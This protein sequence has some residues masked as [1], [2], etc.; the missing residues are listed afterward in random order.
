MNA[1]NAAVASAHGLSVSSICLLKPRTIRKTTSGK[2]A[3]AWC[4]RA[5]LDGSLQLVHRWDRGQDSPDAAPVEEVDARE[6]AVPSAAG[7]A[8]EGQLRIP[9]FTAEEVRGK[10]VEELCRLLQ[11]ALVLLSSSG[12]AKLSPPIDPNTS[13]TALGMDSMTVVQFKGVLERR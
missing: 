3:R 11:D 4:K 6:E 7:P 1:C 8:V 5:Y 2:I 12:P 13:L 10:D 9:R